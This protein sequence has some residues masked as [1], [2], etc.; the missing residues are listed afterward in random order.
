MK[1]CLLLTIHKKKIKFDLIAEL[2]LTTHQQKKLRSYNI[3]KY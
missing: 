3:T 2:R 1:V